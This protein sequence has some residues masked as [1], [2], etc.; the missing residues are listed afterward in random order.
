MSDIIYVSEFKKSSKAIAPIKYKKI[1]SYQ[2]EIA[3]GKGDVISVNGKTYIISD[4]KYVY[5]GDAVILRTFF[6]VD[7]N[8]K[9]VK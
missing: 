2:Y 6:V 8:S 4:V 7:K 5:G 1:A 9:E 3:S